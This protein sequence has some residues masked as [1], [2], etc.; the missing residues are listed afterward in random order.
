MSTNL[1]YVFLFTTP[2]IIF[3]LKFLAEGVGLIDRPSLIKKHDSE[4][5]LLGGISIFLSL[6][7]YSYAF[8]QNDIINYIILASSIIVLIGILDDI[9]SLPIIIRFFFQIIATLIV[10][11]LGI[12]L[13]DFGFIFGNI[14]LSFG[15]FS[16]LITVLVMIGLI[17][18]INFIDGVD[19]LASL[20]FLISL[21]SLLIYYYFLNNNLNIPYFEFIIMLIICVFSA[22][23]FNIFNLIGKKVFLGDAGSTLL[24]FILGC[25]LIIYSQEPNRLFEP[26]LLIWC[27]TL[28]I[29]DL[30]RITLIRLFSKNNPF[31]PDKNHI[32]YIL[33]SMKYSNLS[34]LMILG[35][36]S[37]GFSLFGLMIF[38]YLGSFFS[39]IMYCISF[40]IYL[41]YSFNLKKN[42]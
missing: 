25:L 28:P 13:Y 15:I 34:I 18:A 10:I 9:Y 4:A 14:Y 38:L 23:I 29:F 3:I 33:S 6:I 2:I 22:F 8:N 1:I 32:H 11:G 7:M 36:V 19:G 30:M 12:V 27:V 41:R 5:Y 42:I 24:G 37:L 40:L 35:S 17:N 31:K 16:I 39:F 20:L 21:I 26:L